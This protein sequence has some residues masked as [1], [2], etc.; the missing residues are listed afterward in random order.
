MWPHVCPLVV[1]TCDL[2][3]YYVFVHVLLLPEVMAVLA[4]VCTVTQKTRRGYPTFFLLLLMISTWE[5]ESHRV[6]GVQTFML[7]IFILRT[8]G[9]TH[10][11]SSQL[12][13]TREPGSDLTSVTHFSSWTT[14]FKSSCHHPGSRFH[15]LT[16]CHVQSMK[17]ELSQMLSTHSSFG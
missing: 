5:L 12:E 10:V 2:V 4:R 15:V 1:P 7:L 3:G 16:F 9:K 11:M 13:E 14:Y 6:S 17:S 8:N